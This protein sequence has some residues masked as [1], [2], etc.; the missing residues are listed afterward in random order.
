MLDLLVIKTKSL[1]EGNTKEN[2]SLSPRDE[3]CEKNLKQ[4]RLKNGVIGRV[5][6][7][8]FFPPE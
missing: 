6:Q 1:T 5:L 2:V 3:A 8:S 4:G 7:N